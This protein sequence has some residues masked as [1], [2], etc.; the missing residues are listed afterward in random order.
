MKELE[1]VETVHVA[2]DHFEVL[3]LLPTAPHDL[4]IEAYWD[5]AHRLQ[6]AA[7][8]DPSAQA[9][10][11]RLNQAYA[12]LTHPDDEQ[13]ANLLPQPSF[14]NGHAAARTERRS[15]L[16]R[17]LKRAPNPVQAAP[18]HWELLHILPS[19][20]PDLVKLAYDFWRRQLRGSLGVSAEPALERLSHAYQAIVA[21][22]SANAAPDQADA[23]VELPDRSEEVQQQP[24]DVQQQ[25]AEVQQQTVE[26]QQQTAEIQQQAADETE[27]PAL[28]DPLMDLGI[29]S[30]EVEAPDERPARRPWALRAWSATVSTAGAAGH[31]TRHLLNTSRERIAKWAADPFREND[32]QVQLELELQLPPEP[33]AVDLMNRSDKRLRSLAITVGTEAARIDEIGSQA[34]SALPSDTAERET[35]EPSEGSAGRDPESRAARLVAEN[36]MIWAIGVEALSIGSDPTC[37]ITVGAGS[38]DA[39]HVT[40]RVWARGERVVLHALAAETPVLV[41]GQRVTWALLEDGDTLQV[42]DIM[43]RFDAYITGEGRKA[44]VAGA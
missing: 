9:L 2:E 36:G 30:E 13:R 40:A 32:R 15:W 27:P 34:Y 29:D 43:L 4:V 20:S 8:T 10:L 28:E 33:G 25:A 14:E 31:R 26:V 11:V 42:C 16:A 24:A 37:D 23:G 7:S 6:G 19:A 12:W 22:A 5:S 38:P 21:A 18:N 17:L 39:E 1:V 44:D 35:E 41:N 3:G